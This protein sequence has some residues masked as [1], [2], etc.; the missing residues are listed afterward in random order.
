MTLKSWDDVD[1]CTA[2]L[3]LIVK[4][5]DELR[6]KISRAMIRFELI[7]L[8]DAEWDALLTEVE[9]FKRLCRTISF[10]SEKQAA[11]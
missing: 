4:W 5:R 10:F 7:G 11:A 6:S 3:S 8:T 2:D 9:E 1:R